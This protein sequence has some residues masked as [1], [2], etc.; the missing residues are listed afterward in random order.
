MAQERVGVVT[1]KGDSL[2]LLGPEL[3]VGDRAPDFTVVDQSLNPVRLSDFAGKP[4]LISAV[5][6]L[7]TPVCAQQTR[8]FNELAAQ[9]AKVEI[10]TISE[11]LPFAQ[12]RWCGAAGIDRIRVLSDYREREFGLKY[13]ILIKELKL[14]AR[15]VWVIDGEGIIRFVHIVPELTQL[16][17][18]EAA[19][20]AAREVAGA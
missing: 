2:T 8:R 3:R 10:W 13:G 4:L 7:D 17:D 12:A 18:F 14:L 9:I 6:S 16:P 11:D 1:F 20:A 19:L 5:P 15:S